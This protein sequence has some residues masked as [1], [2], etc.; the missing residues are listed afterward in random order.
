[1][2]AVAPG[3]FG[4]VRVPQALTLDDLGG[5]GRIDAA[6][7]G[8]AGHALAGDAIRLWGGAVVREARHTGVY[9]ALLDVRLR[10][11]VA[12]GCRL[13]LVKGRVDTS[14]PILGRAGFTAYGEERWY[15]L[16]V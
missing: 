1:M 7:F 11:G 14:A 12:A 6:A 13:A 5:T 8:T 4:A 9:R 16:D 3:T 15:F 10:A 2:P